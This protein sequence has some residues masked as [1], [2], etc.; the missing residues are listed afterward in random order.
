MLSELP[1]PPDCLNFYN[2]VFN[3]HRIQVMSWFLLILLYFAIPFKI[4][5]PQ[6][7]P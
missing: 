3:W 5:A 7:N 1:L 6:L 4:L 2:D